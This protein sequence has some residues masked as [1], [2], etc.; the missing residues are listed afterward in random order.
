M[1]GAG[2]ERRRRLRAWALVG[3]L[4][5]LCLR[6]VR[7]APGRAGAGGHHG[8]AGHHVDRGAEHQQPRGARPRRRRGPGDHRR[9]DHGRGGRG[10]HHHVPG[11]RRGP[12]DRAVRAL[13]EGPDPGGPGGRDRGRHHRAD[14]DDR[15]AA[16][17]GSHLRPG[18]RGRVDA[19]DRARLPRR[20]DRSD[21]GRRLLP[22]HVGGDHGGDPGGRR[23]RHDHRG[24]D[25][26]GRPRLP[27]RRR[28]GQPQPHRAGGRDRLRHPAGGGPG[29]RSGR[30]R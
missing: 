3:L 17:G 2:D 14:H 22:G 9:R 27:V 18:R 20:R 10:R 6:L 21:L 11:Q 30:A 25:R 16:P 24:A 5:T 28:P 15:G 19:Q 4:A 29:R 23:R 26:G 7:G 12:R 1:R 13:P 8:G